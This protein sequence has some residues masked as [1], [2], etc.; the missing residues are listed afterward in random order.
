MPP[1]SGCFVLVQC[2]HLLVLAQQNKQS[3]ARS[4]SARW[5]M[6]RCCH[7]WSCCK[8]WSTRARKVQ[9]ICFCAC[10]STNRRFSTGYWQFRL[11]SIVSIHITATSCWE[12]EDCSGIS[13]ASYT[14]GK[15]LLKVCKSQSVQQ[16]FASA[17]IGLLTFKHEIFR[18]FWT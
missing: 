1:F 16:C 9:D 4:W 15:A 10:S 18:E 12:Q 17:R 14:S 3:P 7:L 6:L 5:V 8:H 13:S 11:L 2:L